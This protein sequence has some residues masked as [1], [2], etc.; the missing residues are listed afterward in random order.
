MS[1]FISSSHTKWECKYHIVF[2][3]KYRQKIIYNQLRN[4][5]KKVFHHLTKQKKYKII[6]KHLIQNHIHILITIPP[7]HSISHITGFLKKKSA[8]YITHHFTRKPSNTT[9]QSF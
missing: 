1:E 6:K 8:I 5:L 4:D 9:K 7:K 2:I 3:P